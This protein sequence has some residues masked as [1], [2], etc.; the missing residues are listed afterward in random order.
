MQGPLTDEQ[1]AHDILRVLKVLNTRAN[2]P[3]QYG[4]LLCNI[5]KY[6]SSTVSDIKRGALFL[7]SK[8][9]LILHPDSSFVLTIDGQKEMDRLM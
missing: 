7:A 8:G 6:T 5:E 1:V 4:V 2:A 9:F 3:V